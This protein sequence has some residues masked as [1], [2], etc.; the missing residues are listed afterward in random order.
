MRERWAFD[1][2]E[3]ARPDRTRRSFLAYAIGREGQHAKAVL[4][5]DSPD[6]RR[7]GGDAGTKA[8]D[9]TRTVFGAQLDDPLRAH[10]DA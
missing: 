4:Y 6:P 7:F 5:C 3:I 9:T 10:T 8:I 2:D 1:D